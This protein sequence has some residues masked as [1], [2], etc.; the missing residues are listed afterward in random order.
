[1]EKLGIDAVQLGAQLVNVI[2]LLI[3]LKKF[4]YKPVL[5]ILEKRREQIEGGLMLRDEME[6]KI[7]KL[8][9]KEKD[10]EAKAKLKA[11]ELEA[12]VVKT[13]RQ[14]ADKILAEAK[15]EAE[16]VRRQ[17]K[18]DAKRELELSLGK[19]EAELA[20]K[21]VELANQALGKLLPKDVRAK[22]TEAQIRRLMESVK[23]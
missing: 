14:A 4:L 22:L 12:A 17:A 11:R 3:V 6:G 1:M 5:S 8:E 20:A 9:D 7:K 16:K 10:L 15:S 13:A 19:R 21:A 18:Q 2:I 23:Q